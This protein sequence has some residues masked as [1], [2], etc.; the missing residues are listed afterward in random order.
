MIAD[1]TRATENVPEASPNRLVEEAFTTMKTFSST[2]GDNAVFLEKFRS[3]TNYEQVPPLELV[4]GKDQNQA[5]QRSLENLIRKTVAELGLPRTWLRQLDGG[6]NQK[7]VFAAADLALQVISNIEVMDRLHKMNGKFPFELP[8]GVSIARDRKNNISAIGLSLPENLDNLDEKGRENFA[9]LV[10]WLDKMD[11]RITPVIDQLKEADQDPRSVISWRD[12]EIDQGSL[13]HMFSKHAPRER[14]LFDADGNFVLEVNTK[15]VE[16]D[17]LESG[18]HLKD[19]NLIESRFNLQ[20]DTAGNIIVKQNVQAQYVPFYGY[21]NMFADNIGKPKTI[22]EKR[23]RPDDFVVVRDHNGEI[24]L[25]QAKDLESFRTK[26]QAWHYGMKG[27]SVAFDAGMLATGTIEL[28]MAA[29]AARAVSSEMKLLGLAGQTRLSIAG[30]TKIGVGASGVLEN[31]WGHSLWGDTLTYGRLAYTFGDVLRNGL[32]LANKPLGIQSVNKLGH[33]N[34]IRME[35]SQASPLL[36]R[37][38]AGTNYLTLGIASA[39]LPAGFVQ[40]Y[41]EKYGQDQ[42]RRIGR[43]YADGQAVRD[44]MDR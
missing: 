32:L 29:R 19:V 31:S 21:Q 9:T 5:P 14:G 16:R 1:I 24:D 2:P 35:A 30:A 23:F 4:D 41:R 7:L 15:D 8:Q 26:Q 13:S 25:V 18:Y 39:L 43:A 10:K 12:D 3:K 44:A 22:E 37:T 28:K 36:G 42:A 33:T 17:G 6:E 34:A 11:S 38:M 40:L 27:A 20:T